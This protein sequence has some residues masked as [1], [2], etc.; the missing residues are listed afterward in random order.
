MRIGIVTDAWRPQTNGVVTT[1]SR[2]AR[3]LT[4][5]GHTVALLTPEGL[6]TVP[7]PTYPEIRLTLR[8]GRAA[9]TWLEREPLEALHIATEGPLGFA[10]RRAALAAGLAFTSSYHT[11][12]PEYLRARFPIPIGLTYAALRRFHGTAVRTMVGTAHVR[13]LLAKRG[14][15]HLALWPRGVDTDLFHPRIASRSE[16]GSDLPGPILMYVGRVAVEKN[17]GEF[18]AAKV[19]GTKIVVGGGPALESL[20]RQF[21]E[22]R[23]LGYRYG[24]ELAAVLAAADVFVF[25][26]RTDT[27]GLVMLEALACGVPVAAYPVQGPIDVIRDGEVG[28]LRNDLAEAIDG[29][30]RMDR[31]RCREYAL[32]FRWESATAQFLSQLV[33]IRAGVAAGAVEASSVGVRG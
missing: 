6:A 15:K 28:C 14:F 31:R 26:S 25:P 9:R 33:D 11:Q 29:A 23:F 27:F 12:F 32:S 8:P 10:A 30:L 24:E 16:L 3:C 13:D 22:A 4:E 5:M 20:K 7:C 17:L 1:L 18:L 19:V 21:P 2:T